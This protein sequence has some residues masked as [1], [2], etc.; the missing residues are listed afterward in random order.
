M[1]IDLNAIFGSWDSL[2]VV[3]HVA[4]T[5]MVTQLSK[6]HISW[7]SSDN[8]KAE[9]KQYASWVI[10]IAL[11]IVGKAL[12]VGIFAGLTYF[13]AVIYG[14]ILALVANGVFDIASVKS[15]LTS[16]TTT[17]ETDKKNG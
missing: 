14:F 16:G 4:I 9:F 15:F 11:S 2:I 1:Q 8:A 17:T 13:T 3:V 12:A 7:L 6:F 10:S 5:L